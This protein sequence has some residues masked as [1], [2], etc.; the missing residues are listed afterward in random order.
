M[1]RLIVFII[2]L[3][4]LSVNAAPSISK[5]DYGSYASLDAQKGELTL[6]KG[7]EVLRISI[8]DWSPLTNELTPSGVKL[9]YPEYVCNIY[10]SDEAI[11]WDIILF[12]P[13]KINEFSFK[14]GSS[15]KWF[16]QS[17][18]TEEYAKE[19]CV[20]WTETYI[21]TKSGEYVYRPENV[22]YSY[23]VY[24]SNRDNQYGI[25]KL[26]HVYRPKVYDSSGNWTWGELDYFDGVLTV[27]VNQEWLKKARYPVTIDPSFGKTSIGGTTKSFYG[28]ATHQPLVACNFTSPADCDITT[29][30]IYSRMG[31]GTINYSPSGVVWDDNAGNP[32]NNLNY[33]PQYSVSKDWGWNEL[34]FSTPV[35]VSNGVTYWIGVCSGHTEGKNFD[36]RYDAGSSKIK[37]HDY[38]NYPPGATFGAITE[39]VNNAVMSI[40]ANYTV[41]GGASLAVH[42]S[43]YGGDDLSGVGVTVWNSLG[44]YINKLNTN[45]TGYADF[46]GVAAD[47]YTIQAYLE[48]YETLMLNYSVTTSYILELT[49]R[50]FEEALAFNMELLIFTALGSICLYIGYTV[51]SF[52]NKVGAYFM[53]CVFWVASMYQWIVSNPNS[54][55]LILAFFAPFLWGFTQGMH[56]LAALID[57]SMAGK[58]D[59]FE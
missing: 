5:I 40:Y 13:L 50:T 51:P 6:T 46:G 22:T 30:W 48:G 14:V 18:L 47:N 59:P 58:R 2:L 16:Y 35:N 41:P 23:A 56:S 4:T 11:E 28:D 9:T 42:V 17:P 45:S 57:T 29:I 8:L 38:D 39:T 55:G 36:V 24:G 34:N 15:L 12:S 44:V 20:V 25:G 1:K 19:N 31:A 10:D 27:K 43:D 7:T 49:L 53:S 21:Q 33:T 54:Y 52:T 32:N 3:N 37:N 26:T